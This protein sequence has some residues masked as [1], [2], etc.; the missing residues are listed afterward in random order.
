MEPGVDNVTLTSGIDNYSV[1]N[2][3]RITK[4]TVTLKLLQAHPDNRIFSRWH[5]SVLYGTASLGIVV[6]TGVDFRDIAIDCLPV[7]K[8]IYQRKA[9]E[10]PAL[11]W[12][13]LSAHIQTDQ[14]L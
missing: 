6:V 10:V 14:P 4:G 8:A 3:N 7:K 5:D 1:F 11:E 13:F 9:S 2:I 12:T